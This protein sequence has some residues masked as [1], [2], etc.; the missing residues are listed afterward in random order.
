MTADMWVNAILLLFAIGIYSVWV[1]LAKK[2]IRKNKE[3]S[4]FWLGP[5]GSI[6][7]KSLTKSSRDKHDLYVSLILAAN[8]LVFL[9]LFWILM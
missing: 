8:F 2:S 7:L 1:M 9:L 6:M 3:S 5:I 4:I